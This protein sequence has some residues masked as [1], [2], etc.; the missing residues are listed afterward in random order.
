MEKQKILQGSINLH[1]PPTGVESQDVLRCGNSSTPSEASA[2]LDKTIHLRDP[3][4]QKQYDLPS[5]SSQNKRSSGGT[6]ASGKMCLPEGKKKPFVDSRSF[7][8]RYY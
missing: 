6:A 8:D 4:R 5:T 7:F 3:S 2:S 1:S